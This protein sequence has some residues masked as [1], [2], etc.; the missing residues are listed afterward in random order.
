MRSILRALVLVSMLALSTTASA[1]ICVQAVD[2]WTG[3]A[4]SMIRP[5]TKVLGGDLLCKSYVLTGHCTLS[6]CNEAMRN[7]RK[8]IDGVY[9]E[10]MLKVAL[11]IRAFGGDSKQKKKCQREI[12]DR[13]IGRGNYNRLY[14]TLDWLGRHCNWKHDCWRRLTSVCKLKFG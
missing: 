1:Q 7:L 9:E 3:G 4:L 14:N 13:S 8:A 12:V 5:F 2:K 6:T 11:G 10:N